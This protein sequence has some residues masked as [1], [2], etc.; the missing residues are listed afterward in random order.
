MGLL[1][2]KPDQVVDLRKEIAALRV[3]LMEKMERE[4]PFWRRLWPS[5]R[6]M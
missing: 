5:L 4:S 2:R 1:S 3:Q 6:R